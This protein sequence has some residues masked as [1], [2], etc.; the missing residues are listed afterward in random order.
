MTTAPERISPEV[1][2]R[3]KDYIKHAASDRDREML[4]QLLQNRRRVLLERK[5][6]VAERKQDSLREG[7]D[8]LHRDLAEMRHTL[9]EIKRDMNE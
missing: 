2:Q 7:I 1:I 8:E 5:I 9:E 4:E 3:L 6:W